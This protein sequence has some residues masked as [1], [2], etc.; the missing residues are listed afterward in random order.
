MKKWPVISLGRTP[1]LI[2]PAIYGKATTFES[3]YY[4]KVITMNYAVTISQATRM[5]CAALG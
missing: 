4:A 5:N 3:R 2:A 1:E